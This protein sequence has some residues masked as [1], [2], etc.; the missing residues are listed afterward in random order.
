MCNFV[1]N[2]ATVGMY[3][4]TVKILNLHNV[5]GFLY[6]LLLLYLTLLQFRKRHYKKLINKISKTKRAC[7]IYMIICGTLCIQFTYINV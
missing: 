4:G 3:L 7:L 2:K 1:H 5:R 6:Y